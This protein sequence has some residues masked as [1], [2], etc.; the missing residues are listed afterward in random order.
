LLSALALAVAVPAFAQN[1]D[2]PKFLGVEGGSGYGGSGCPNGTA[3]IVV[4]EDGQ[5]IS[6][7]FD[8][9]SVASKNSETGKPSSTQDARKSCNIRI[10]TSVPAGYSV[11]LITGDYRGY[12]SFP[13]GSGVKGRMK[14]EYFY[15]GARGPVFETV[16]PG[17]YTTVDRRPYPD[18]NY[19]EA[20]GDFTVTHKLIATAW[21]QCG[22]QPVLASNINLQID[23]SYRDASL[24]LDSAD[25]KTEPLLIYRLK[26][27]RCN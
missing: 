17:A 1:S 20:Q 24:T 22:F 7:I 14:A 8:Q 9:F 10:K 15:A 23:P 5:T 25:F 6:Y 19:N 2:V 13:R 18:Y 12:S 27:Q 4:A 26:W 21:S 16:F 3:N 11:S